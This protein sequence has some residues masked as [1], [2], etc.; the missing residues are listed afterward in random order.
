M[1]VQL[2]S[3]DELI[4]EYKTLDYSIYE[5][6]SYGLSDMLRIQA[7]ASEIEQR[8]LDLYEY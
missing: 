8:G 5:A 2:M 3:D 7:V 4:K 6:Q 1:Q